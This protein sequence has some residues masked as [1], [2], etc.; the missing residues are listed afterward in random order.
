MYKES[1]G[2]NQRPWSCETEPVELPAPLCSFLIIYVDT[3]SVM[4]WIPIRLWRCQWFS[5]HLNKDH[6]IHVFTYFVASLLT[7]RWNCVKVNIIWS[8]NLVKFHFWCIP[9]KFIRDLLSR[10]VPVY[11]V[12]L[13]VWKRVPC[14]GSSESTSLSSVKDQD[15]TTCC[16]H[17][18]ETSLSL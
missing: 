11:P 3:S 15:T 5:Q 7:N 16:A 6:L 4:D 2:L 18:E 17:W 13:K 14:W 9:V 12:V 1:S 10:N 8:V